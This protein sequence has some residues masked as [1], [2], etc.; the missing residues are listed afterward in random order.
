MNPYLSH[1]NIWK[2]TTYDMY[3]VHCILLVEKLKIDA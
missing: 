2:Q 1:P 3:T